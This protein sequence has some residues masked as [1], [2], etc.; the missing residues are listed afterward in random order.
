MSPAA[1]PRC[2]LN[3]ET[4]EWGRHLILARCEYHPEHLDNQAFVTASIEPPAALETAI[5]KRRTEY[6]AGR[7]CARAAL[8][9]LH[10]T[11]AVPGI[12]EDRAPRWPAG[13]VG[14][15]THSHG[16]AAVLVGETTHWQ[17]LGL[18]AE[19]WL[20]PARAQRLRDEILTVGERTALHDLDTSQQARRIT[21]VFSVKES[22]FKALYPITGQ[23]FYFQDAEIRDDDSI[24]LCRTLSNDWRAG[25]RLP[26]QWRE[27][28]E[29]V[30][31]WI[32]VPR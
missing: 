16:R 8:T 7:A 9:R 32:T 18:D 17:G 22:L 4:L 24:T 13:A 1:L 20:S 2:L 29:G 23:R 26:I 11:P 21:R 6:L 10:G 30:L 25:A 31:S 5:A 14:A 27:E 28:E 12:G 19:R 3:L 15:I